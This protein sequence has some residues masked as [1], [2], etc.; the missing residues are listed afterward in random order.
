MGSVAGLDLRAVSSVVSIAVAVALAGC[1]GG[2]EVQHASGGGDTTSAATGTGGGGGAP[3]PITQP[4]APAGTPITADERKWTWV[5][6]DGMQCMDGSPTGIGINPSKSTNKV[7]I[8]LEGGG[9]CFNDVTCTVGTI[10]PN[11]FDEVAFAAE[12]TV[13][14]YSGALNRNLPTNPFSE[15]SYIFIPY[16]TGDVHAGNNPNGPNGRHHVGFENMRLA[17]QRI[18]PTF[19]TADQVV[20]TGSSAGGV[21]AAYNF[22]QVQTAFGKVPVTLLDDSGPVLPDMYLKPCLQAQMRAAWNLDA[23]LPKDCTACQQADGG[24]LINLPLYLM[25]KYPDRRCG[26]ISSNADIV[27]RTFYGFGESADCKSPYVMSSA[28]FSAGL[29]ALRTSLEAKGDNFHVYYP[30]S[31]MHTWLLTDVQL[32]E[33][34]S[35]VKLSD[36]MRALV[37]GTD[38]FVDV[39]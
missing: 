30:T 17:L 31:T 34:Q 35:G 12:I 5:P 18:V 8:V 4:P 7:V 21:G 37:D 38:A 25:S 20:L 6:I 1:A 28:D 26:L 19:A 3:P 10:N 11:G 33:V 27:F 14:G 29:D 36:W 16:C 13:M 24:G 39:P 15:W 32:S 22:D 2:G 23:T 9:A